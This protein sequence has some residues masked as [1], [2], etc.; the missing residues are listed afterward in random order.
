MNDAPLLSVEHL[1]V[2]LVPRRGEPRQLVDDVSFEVRANEVLGMAGESGSGKTLT[3]MAILRLLATRSLRVTGRIMFDG[4][5]L[6]T[7]PVKELRR[8]RGSGIAVVFQEPMSSLHPSIRIGEQIAEGVRLHR[9]VSRKAAWDRAVE[10]LE[11]VGIPSPA[12][13]AQQYPHEFSGGMQQRVMLA[14]ALACEPRLLIADEPTTAL[15]VTIQA[16]IVD[17]LRDLQQRVGMSVLFV[18]HDLGLLSGLADRVQ[19][20]YAGQIV[21]TATTDELFARPRHPYTQALI[22]SAPHPDLKGGRL[23]T[24]PGS[25]PRPAALPAGCR[26]HPR[27]GFVVDRCRSGDVPLERG[28]GDRSCR[29]IRQDELDL[30]RAGAQ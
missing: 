21:E 24:I 14:I 12:T 6:L 1:G 26:F 25:P 5:D 11:L 10:V 15:D 20:M 18:T 9:D 3:S 22:R 19:V 17:L 30:A 4:R 28:H 29:C 13:R 27:C 16:Q 2:Q 23:P 8:V 7:M